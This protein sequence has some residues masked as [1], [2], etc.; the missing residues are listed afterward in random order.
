MS[1]ARCNVNVSGYSRPKPHYPARSDFRPR[2]TWELVDGAY[3]RV[4]FSPSTGRMRTAWVE[5]ALGGWRWRVMERWP[6]GRVAMVAIG[7]NDVIK[8]LA[9]MCF[10]YADLAAVT[11]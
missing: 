11:R 7:S 3:K 6:R 1:A 4:F 5:R 10:G 8:P 9:R 2:T